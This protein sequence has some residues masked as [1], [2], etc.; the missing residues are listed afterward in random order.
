ME[1]KLFELLVVTIVV[2][3]GVAVPI[4]GI[5]IEHRTRVRALGVIRVYAERGEEPPLS[6]I[7]AL[8][9]VSRWAVNGEATPK[10][11][12]TRGGHL[13]HAAG[14]VVF[15]VGLGGF[16]WWRIATL[17]KADTLAI[18]VLFVALFFAAGLAARL[19]GAYYAPDR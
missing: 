7:Q 6:V 3:L 10:K 14:N 4:S 9:P 2:G 19:V 1:G 8:M 12:Q 13:A 17:G 18:V 5:W 11:A 16:A 15:A